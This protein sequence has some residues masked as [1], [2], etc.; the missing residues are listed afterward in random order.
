MRLERIELWQVTRLMTNRQ[1]M[2][3]RLQLKF[4]LKSVKVLEMVSIVCGLRSNK[5]LVVLDDL[6][7]LEHIVHVSVRPGK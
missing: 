3:G 4:V 7:K 5:Q 2:I 1:A 6:L